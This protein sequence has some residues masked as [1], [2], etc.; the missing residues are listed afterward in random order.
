MLTKIH[1]VTLKI[2]EHALL[3]H[4]P[5]LLSRGSLLDGS[6]WIVETCDKV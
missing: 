4:V 2:Y 5:E 6:S 3:E 1:K